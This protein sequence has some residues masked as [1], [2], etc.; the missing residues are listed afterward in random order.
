MA[1]VVA[2]AAERPMSRRAAVEVA[3]A[4]ARGSD[5]MKTKRA[6]AFTVVTIACVVTI[7]AAIIAT[8]RDHAATGDSGGAAALLASHA[9]GSPLLMFRSLDGPT[10]GQLG[11]VPA[12]KRNAAVR[13]ASLRCDRVYYRAGTGL[14][15]GR[16]GGFAPGYRAAGV[17]AGFRGRRQLDPGRPPSR[18]PGSPRGRPRPGA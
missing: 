13:Y 4:L 2:V 10:S 6:R 12:G 9:S 5:V 17:G 1:D 3:A 11:V 16:G 8:A 7:A 14:C 15:V 18:A